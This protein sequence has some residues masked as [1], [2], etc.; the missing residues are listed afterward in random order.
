M[1]A[2]S[3]NRKPDNRRSAVIAAMVFVFSS[4]L[5]ISGCGTSPIEHEQSPCIPTFDTSECTLR[6]QKDNASEGSRDILPNGYLVYG[7][8]DH[9]STGRGMLLT[10]MRRYE[11]MQVSNTGRDIVRSI[12]ISNNGDWVLYIDYATWTPW[13]IRPN[14]GGKTRIPVTGVEP[15]FPQ[16]AGFYRQSPYGCE[17]F[18]LAGPDRLHAIAVDLSGAAPVFGRDRVIADLAGELDF[19]PFRYRIAVCKDQVFGAINPL[20]GDTAV[21]RTGYLTIPDGGRGTAGPEH[22]YGWAEDDT[23]ETY[24][25]FHTMSHDGRY[26][27]ANAGVEGSPSV[28]PKGHKG[29]YITAFRRWCDP[30]VSLDRNL[31]CFGISANWVPEPYRSLPTD[32]ADFLYWYFTNDSRYVVGFMTGSRAD[33]RCVWL[34]SWET[35]TWTP[36][37]PTDKML[38]VIHPAAY[39]GHMPDSAFVQVTDT[40]DTTISLQPF[41]DRYDP[42]YEVISPNGGETYHVG[43]TLVIQISASRS[44]RAIM[45]IHVEK[46]RIPL[47]LFETAFNPYVVR[48][49]RWRI[50]PSVDMVGL[51]GMRTISLVSNRC[52]IEI[53]DYA[54]S[55]GRSDVSDGFFT[56]LPAE[57]TTE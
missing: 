21:S 50:P 54:E 1:G 7:N 24:G 12:S 28:I 34:V 30:P 52:L 5:L 25:C 48:D 53:T 13:L 39:I 57:Q 6:V 29:F 56:I 8:D 42:D 45:Y 4:L 2:H 38:D 3:V 27:L 51:E 33:F 10:A 36:L 49:L 55:W 11:P 46:E 32:Q 40:S 37:T 35:N 43:D 47:P 9:D 15:G 20:K 17:V 18:Y 31:D 16:W 23:I 19:Y 44:A 41:D 14:G 22:I 26:V